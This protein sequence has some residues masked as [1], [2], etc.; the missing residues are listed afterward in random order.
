Q[1]CGEP[2]RGGPGR[3]GRV[4]GRAGAPRGRHPRDRDPRRAEEAEPMST[5][6]LAPLVFV[7]AFAVA[8]AVALLLGRRRPHP[9]PR[10]PGARRILVPFS[11]SL[12]PT[13]LDAAIR[14]A[15]AEESV[16]VPA[17]LLI[18]PP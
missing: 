12:D 7:T 8:L 6:D 3:L 11:G 9:V 16:L 4:R 14:I 2:P 13:V 1:T 15:R 10:R 18:V 17:Y 5:L